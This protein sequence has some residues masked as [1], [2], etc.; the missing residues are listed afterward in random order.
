MNLWYV[1]CK[2]CTYLA[3]RVALSPN[4]PNRAPPDPRHLEVPSGVSKMIY[5]PMVDLTQ[6]E[7]L[8]CIDPNTVSNR[9]KRVPHDPHH[10]EVPSGASN[11]ISKTMARSTQ[12]VH[13]SCIKSSTIS[14]WTKMR[15]HMTHVTHEFYR[16]RSKLFMSLCYVQCK[17]CTYLAWR[18]ALSP[19]RPN[20]AP[21]DPRHLRVP[22]G[23]SKMIYEPLVC[24]T[25]TEQL[26]CTD[27][28]IVSK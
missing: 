7:H 1:P 20:R 18:L 25:Q 6:T 21:L 26:S 8:S 16:V 10:L 22:S 15:L 3:S 11:T 5:D 9:S 14:K 24:L 17:P 2:P 19:I 13:Q 12:T 28:K 4:R 23:T 27:A